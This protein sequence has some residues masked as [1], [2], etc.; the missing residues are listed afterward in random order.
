MTLLPL[1]FACA[2]CGSRNETTADPS[3]G[4]RQRYV[5]DCATCC[6]PNVLDVS[7]ERS[8]ASATAELE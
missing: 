1:T 8:E 6:R 4:R 2:G 3:Q 7:I 5:E